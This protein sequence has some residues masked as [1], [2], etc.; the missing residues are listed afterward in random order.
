MVSCAPTTCRT[1]VRAVLVAGGSAH[2]SETCCGDSASV[3]AWASTRV[4]AARTDSVTTTNS[5][6]AAETTS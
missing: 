5:A 2:A 1:P 3:G 4:V 6:N